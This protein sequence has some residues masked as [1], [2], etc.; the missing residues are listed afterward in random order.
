MDMTHMD[1][2]Q[3]EHDA[4]TSY[5]WL[6]VGVIVLLFSI[7]AYIWASRTQGKILGHMKKKEART[8]TKKVAPFG[9]LHT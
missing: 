9:W 6:I 5:L 1:H 2:M 8:S 3:M 4:G 7:A